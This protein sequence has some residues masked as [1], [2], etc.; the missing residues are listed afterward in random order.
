MST[1]TKQQAEYLLPLMLRAR[2]RTA[3]FA[4]QLGYEHHKVRDLGTTVIQ[5]S[6]SGILLQRP[7]DAAKEYTACPTGHTMAKWLHCVHT[8][9]AQARIL[10]QEYLS[11][12]W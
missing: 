7:L 6:A 8:A 10:T 5:T 3:F 4:V 9:H 2:V 1:T 11:P 12:E